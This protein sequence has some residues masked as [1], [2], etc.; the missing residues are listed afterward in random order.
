MKETE[1]P[2]GQLFGVPYDWRRPNWSR[3]RSRIWNPT[4]HRLFTPKPFGHGHVVNGYWLA[5]P[6]Q[7]WKLRR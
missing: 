2:Q 3:V 5:H 4:D 6:I 7:Y 1:Q